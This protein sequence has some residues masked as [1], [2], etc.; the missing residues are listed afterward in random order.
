MKKLLSLVLICAMGFGM[1]SCVE[2]EESQS[3]RDIRDA[4]AEQLKALTNLYDA[5]AKA[6]LLVAEAEAALKA[7]EAAH[8]A[9]LTAQAKEEYAL[10]L[11][12]LVATYEATLMTQKYK[13]AKYEKLLMDELAKIEKAAEAELIA[14]YTKY[15][16]YSV[17]LNTANESLV[18]AKVSMAK[19]EAEIVTVKEAAEIAIA[20]QEEIIA[21]QEAIIANN[22][23]ILDIY[24]GHAFSDLDADSLYLEYQKAYAEWNNA[25][26]AYYGTEEKVLKEAKKEAV[27]AYNKLNKSVTE[28]NTQNTPS[29]YDNF[30]KKNE[31]NEANKWPTKEGI[32]NT[33]TTTGILS[34]SVDEKSLNRWKKEVTNTNLEDGVTDAEEKLEKAETALE[35]F[36]GF[37]ADFKKAAEARD[38]ILAYTKAYDK[39]DDEWETV[40]STESLLNYYIENKLVENA[41]KAVEKASSQLD[42]LNKVVLAEFTAEDYGKWKFGYWD[43]TP[44]MIASME[45]FLEKLEE[46][47]N[48]EEN[49]KT[50]EDA[51]EALTDEATD[52]QV[53]AAETAVDNA[54]KAVADAEKA[55]KA[56]YDKAVYEAEVKLE[57][58]KQNLAEWE[59]HVANQEK[60]VATAKENQKALID[61]FA[62]AKAAVAT[63]DEMFKDGSEFRKFREENAKWW[64]VS[65]NYDNQDINIEKGHLNRFKLAGFLKDAN[66]DNIP[67]QQ[68]DAAGV[69]GN[70]GLYVV[71]TEAILYWDY[72]PGIED[73]GTYSYYK[74]NKDG[75]EVYLAVE[76][77]ELLEKYTDAV[78]EAKDGMTTANI[79]LAKA[80]EWKGNW[81]AKEKELRDFVAE[82]NNEIKDVQA[83]MDEYN[84]AQEV[85]AAASEKVE[86]LN[87]K[88]MA[89]RQMWVLSEGLDTSDKTVSD[90]IEE[91]E[92]DIKEAEEAIEAAKAEIKSHESK[93]DGTTDT[94]EDSVPYKEALIAQYKAQIENY[95][96]EVEL[97]TQLVKDAKAALDAAMSAQNAE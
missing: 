5:Q 72:A 16:D 85:A 39:Y 19:V 28:F 4:K 24:K 1:I 83:L 48:A 31:D 27:N 62:A 3:V 57:S 17:A 26:L 29:G 94:W 93:L 8:Q 46:L 87:S 96:A 7:A 44:E 77:N 18:K 84:E 75:K 33:E 49:L 22:K 10:K 40:E 47:E 6:A 97:Y 67:D 92:E 45:K 63:L 12:S 43:R 52:E 25:E 42:T 21:E 65:I 53:E 9:E 91:I 37:E 11:E 95:T 70:N 71:E 81:D 14:L 82:K 35:T 76:Y 54:K 34:Y 73:N 56:A 80:N 61:A 59:N 74:I 58:E 38:A 36:K 30:I 23:T 88:Y 78:A 66:N 60:K 68:M 69:V 89:I 55:V 51:L 41:E 90:M 2:S 64:N 13:K 50:K 86:Q 15:S 32:L 20:E 79:N